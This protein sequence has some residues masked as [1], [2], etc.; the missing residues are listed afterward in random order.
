[1]PKNPSGHNIYSGG[2]S[3]MV[4]QSPD[5]NLDKFDYTNKVEEEEESSGSKQGSGSGLS[6]VGTQICVKIMSKIAKAIK[7]IFKPKS[8]K[9]SYED[10]DF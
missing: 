5:D 6:G 9:D 7:K 3:K 1:M 8:D 2:K 4:F 10:N